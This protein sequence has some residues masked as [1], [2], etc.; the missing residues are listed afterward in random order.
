MVYLVIRVLYSLLQ[1]IILATA[2]RTGWNI[3]TKQRGYMDRNRNNTSVWVDPLV[4]P[5]LIIIL[6]AFPI[7]LFWRGYPLSQVPSAGSLIVVFL[8]ISVYFFLLLLFLPMLRKWFTARLCATLWLIPVF[9][10]YQLN[11]LFS[12]EVFPCAVTVY[13]PSGFFLPSFPC[14]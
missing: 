7:P 5:V 4:F 6:F 1:G 9:L 14:G 2:F 12:Y 11:L 3:E 10:F 8:F 13:I